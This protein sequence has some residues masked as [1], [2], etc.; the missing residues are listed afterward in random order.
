MVPIPSIETAVEVIYTGVNKLIQG[1]TYT[2][3]PQKNTYAYKRITLLIV[4]LPVNWP[5]KSSAGSL[6]TVKSEALGP[7][8]PSN[9]PYRY[10][11]STL[12]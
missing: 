1:I 7:S 4:Y 12:K 11:S 8:W 10:V 6:W 2:P 3:L 5:S 9:T